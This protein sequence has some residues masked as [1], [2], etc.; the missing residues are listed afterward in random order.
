LELGEWYSRLRTEVE[1]GTQLQRE[2]DQ[3]KNLEEQ[4]NKEFN[5]GATA[6]YTNLASLRRSMNLQ[7]LKV[8]SSPLIMGIA[9]RAKRFENKAAALRSQ[10]KPHYE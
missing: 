9:D 3:L 2:L 4:L 6:P 8:S 10:N 1:Q 7:P 5:K